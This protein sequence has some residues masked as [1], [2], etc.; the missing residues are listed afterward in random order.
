MGAHQGP[1][2]SAHVKAQAA[3]FGRLF[4]LAVV[5]PM[6]QLINR[7]HVTWALAWAVVV[8]AGEVAYQQWRK[9][10]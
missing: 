10:S 7:G 6:W 1:V 8:G 5:P 2:L 4:A 9:T 3:R